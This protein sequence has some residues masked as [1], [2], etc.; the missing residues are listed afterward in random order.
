MHDAV[1]FAVMVS[2]SGVVLIPALQSDTAIDTSIQKHREELA[3][4]TLLMLMTSRCDDFGYTLAGEQIEDLT[5]INVDYKGSNNN[6]I[7][8]LIKTFLGREQKHKTYS[9]LCVENLVC[10][11]NVFDNRI[12]IF[13][14]SFD[15]N[16]KDELNEVLDEYLGEKYRFNLVTK[17]RPILGIDFGGSMEI[18]IAP[19]DTTHVARTYATLPSTY[20]SDWM[21][22]ID[23]FIDDAVE[24]VSSF[25]SDEGKLKMQLK[26]LTNDII[27][28][29]VIHGFNGKSSIINKTIDYVFFP[30]E[31]GIEKILGNSADMVLDPLEQVC[32]GVTN[33]LTDKIIEIVSTT[34]GLSVTD[35]DGDGSIGCSDAIDC[36]KGYVVHEVEGMLDGVFDGY[37]DSFVDFIVDTLDITS[38]IDELKQN[39]TDFIKEH[40]NPL[41]AEFVITIWEVRG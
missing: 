19:P 27:D 30:I 38:Q 40:I 17:W 2:L 41:R 22:S 11:L 25:A 8:N 36:L 6:I 14:S 16:L 31:N 35:S 21:D 39:I 10:Q 3:D 20:F 32:P 29:I 34:I 33:G 23:D 15:S 1:L 13:T 4:E 18:G 9:D 24:D 37:L 5:N 12:N 28:K 26:N 7:E